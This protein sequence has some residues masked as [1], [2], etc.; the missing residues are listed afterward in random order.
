MKLKY[1][2]QA[3]I[4]GALIFEM[5]ACG[6]DTSSSL[7][8]NIELPKTPVFFI[9]G[10]RRSCKPTSDNDRENPKGTGLYPALKPIMEEIGQEMG[11]TPEFFSACHYNGS[12]DLAYVSSW[13]SDVQYGQSEEQVRQEI[14]IKRGQIDE[15][16]AV[17]IGHSYGGWVVMSL[18]SGLGTEEKFGQ[19]YTVD[20]ISKITCSP[21]HPTGCQSAPGDINAAD[22]AKIADLTGAWHNYYQET[23]P[24]LHSSSISNADTNT[25][26][27]LPHKKIDEDPRL[28]DDIHQQILNS[29]RG[30]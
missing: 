11:E 16:Q 20:A 29:F 4:G 13:N 5:L 10:G 14:L 2:I 6:V 21:T 23:T 22:R 28:W 24:Y 18:A 17:M 19:L 27:D 26:S 15:S 3:V 7:S 12:Q 9:V 25:L 30:T 8:S 1:S